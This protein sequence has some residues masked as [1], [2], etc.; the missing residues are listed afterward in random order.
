MTYLL[1]VNVLVALT[2]PNHTHHVAARG[3]LKS[4]VNHGIATCAITEAG[5]VRLSMTPAVV[6][7]LIPYQTVLD[8]LAVFHTNPRHVFWSAD[9]DYRRA[10]EGLALTGHSQA[11]DAY[12]LGL[13]VAQN[14]GLATFDE[15]IR[16]L[17]VSAGY[18]P[19][20]V[21]VIKRAG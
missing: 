12:L 17:A 4:I 14:G 18:Q 8:A 10:T 21:S 19:E 2:W 6:G 5:F 15:G 13:A 16:T 7:V 9:L 11:T 20:V 3:W 1:D